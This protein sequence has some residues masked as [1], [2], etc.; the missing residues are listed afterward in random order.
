MIEP[1]TI[2]INRYA[3]PGAESIN[4]YSIDGGESL[5]FG[6]LL[7][8]VCIRA[9]SNMEA[10]SIN[11][12]NSMNGN[13]ELLKIASTYLSQLATNTMTKWAS[14]IVF[15]RTKL[16]LKESELPSGHD[17]SY[18]TRFA[19]IN[20]MKP[21]MEAMTRQAQEDMID[22]QSLISKRDVCFTTGTSL[23]KSTGG[24]SEKIAETF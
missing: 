7:A 1:V 22:V 12:M 10:Q 24:S 4:M 14:F 5:T 2:A 18:N 23:I 17:N 8:A 9:G 19:Y 13:V 11:K 6:Q 20:V 21:K 3:P 15:L 16:G